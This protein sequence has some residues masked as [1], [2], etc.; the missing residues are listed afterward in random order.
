MTYNILALYICG[1]V[2]V[3]IAS[4]PGGVPQGVGCVHH[5]RSGCIG[6]GDLH[7]TVP[8]GHRSRLEGNGLRRYDRDH[9]D[10]CT[11][12]CLV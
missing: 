4:C 7:A 6:A 9:S 8:T 10:S 11:S 2:C 5:H 3:C 1:C 12:P